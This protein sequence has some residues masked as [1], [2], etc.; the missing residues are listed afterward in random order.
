MCVCVCD[1]QATVG[2]VCI[3]DEGSPMM[4]PPGRAAAADDRGQLAECL[5]F[6]SD[7]ALTGDAPDPCSD[8]HAAAPSALPRTSPQ[9][10]D[11]DILAGHQLSRREFL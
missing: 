6:I 7:M 1:K 9:P 4:A 8:H 10:T 3:V 2:V 5:A 11:D